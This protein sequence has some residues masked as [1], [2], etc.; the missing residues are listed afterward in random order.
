MELDENTL[1]DGLRFIVGTW[2]V[3]YI[4]N[5]FSNDLAH[6]PAAEFKGEDGS[7]FEN[8]TYSFFEDHPMIMKDTA[9]GKEEH[10]TWE[11]V[12]MLEY[13]YTL[14]A[15]LK[16]PDSSFLDAAQKLDVIDGHIVFSIGFL[17][18]AMK[19][20]EEGHI[21]KEPDI[22]ERE[23][24]AEDLAMNDIVGSYEVAKAMAFADGS[25]EMRTKDEVLVFV[26]KQKAAG[27]M[28]EEDADENL[29]MYNIRIDFTEDHKVVQW[30]PLPAGVSEE[31]IKEAQAAGELGDIKDGYF[32]GG[33]PREWKALDGKY[34]YDTGEEREAFGEK[35][36]SWDELAK[37][38]EGLIKFMSGMV[39]IRR[40]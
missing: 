14:G 1:K 34:Y 19:K 20:I 4:V 21:T 27:A 11:Q 31:Q 37:D 24:S 8:V 30:M 29:R 33:E 23:P 12:N 32:T 40:I 9:S 5:A 28:S 6:I 13:R 7:T 39:M 26:E 18:I 2:Q 35:L 38:D 17:A 36:S 22:G 16:I 10:G 15:F 3:D 25:F